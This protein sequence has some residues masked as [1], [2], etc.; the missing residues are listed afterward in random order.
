M[1]KMGGND[2]IEME[3]TQFKNVESNTKGNIQYE[4]DRL[5]QVDSEAE[6]EIKVKNVDPNAVEF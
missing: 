2:G 3:N 1:F 4:D 6:E 5:K